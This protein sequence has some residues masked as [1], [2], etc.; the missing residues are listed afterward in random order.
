MRER[1]ETQKVKYLMKRRA[2]E[3]IIVVRQGIISIVHHTLYFF[4]GPLSWPIL[5]CL[6]NKNFAKNLG[7]LPSCGDVRNVFVL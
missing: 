7:F 3:P 1:Y 2:G 5:L 6:E 4:L